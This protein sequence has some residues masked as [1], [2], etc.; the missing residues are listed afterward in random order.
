MSKCLPH[1]GSIGALKILVRCLAV[2]T[3]ILH[4][5]HTVNFDDPVARVVVNHFI[6]VVLG[7]CVPLFKL[8]ITWVFWGVRVIDRGVRIHHRI[9]GSNALHALGIKDLSKSI[10]LELCERL[11]NFVEAPMDSDLIELGLLLLRA[12]KSHM[13]FSVAI[14]L[15]AISLH[16]IG[17]VRCKCPVELIC[18]FLF[19]IFVKF[20]DVFSFV[21]IA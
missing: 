21:R 9:V 15:T 7:L 12:I 6:L 2:E 3:P 16:E 18:M 14:L 8:E 20:F 10:N 4:A 19:A 11:H 17:F 13:L 1:I 5:V